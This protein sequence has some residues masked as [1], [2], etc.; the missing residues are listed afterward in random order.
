MEKCR[1][2]LGMCIRSEK[3]HK[4][5]SYLLALMSIVMLSFSVL[6]FGGFI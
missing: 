3:V 6:Y 2:R 4:I 1:R 5:I